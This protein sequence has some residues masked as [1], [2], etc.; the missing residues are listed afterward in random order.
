ME[1]Q[2]RKCGEETKRTQ[3]QPELSPKR[4]V[5]DT[6]SHVSHG[7]WDPHNS[8]ARKDSCL[9]CLP[10]LYPISSLPASSH[11]L[12][13]S[14]W[15]LID[16]ASTQDGRKMG[17]I[18]LIFLPTFIVRDF[19]ARKNLSFS[20]QFHR[21]IHFLK[22]IRMIPIS[23]N[24][25]DWARLITYF[26]S[27]ISYICPFRLTPGSFFMYRHCYLSNFILLRREGDSK[28]I[29]FPFPGHFS[30]LSWFPFL[31]KNG[32]WKTNSKCL[33]RS[34]LLG[35]HSN[36]SPSRME[37]LRSFQWLSVNDS[38]DRILTPRPTHFP[39]PSVHI[40]A[41]NNQ[42]LSH[43]FHLSPPSPAPVIQLL[44][45]DVG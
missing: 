27:Q 18:M 35:Y 21:I 30:E 28:L 23:F 29:F 43:L 37:F 39:A 14:Q 33:V 40:F 31:G 4:A 36:P 17:I 3:L 13:N 24:E 45:T 32:V 16:P 22:N 20:F 1:A 6:S 42:S 9:L 11:Q 8:R 19:T 38:S 5:W 15:L 2:P 10:H 25:F 44:N 34:P 41:Q 7:S 12:D 26:D